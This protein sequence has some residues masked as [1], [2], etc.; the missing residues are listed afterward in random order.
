VKAQRRNLR[1]P[2]LA[3]IQRDDDVQVGVPLQG[4]VLGDRTGVECFYGGE[5]PAQF[6]GD[7]VSAGIGGLA[8]VAGE[9]NV[10]VERI[11]RPDTV[12]GIVTSLS[13]VPGR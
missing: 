8:P 9:V 12:D 6:A 7:V 3:P 10:V 13:R 1:K 11:K 5:R 2:R 4:G